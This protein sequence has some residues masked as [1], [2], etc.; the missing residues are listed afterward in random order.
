MTIGNSGFDMEA[1]RWIGSRCI[2]VGEESSE[3]GE[4]DLAVP[5]LWHAANAL[6]ERT[7]P[8]PSRRERAVSTRS[9][10]SPGPIWER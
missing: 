2:F 8:R 5:S 6:A 3:V 4:V 10:R 9:P 7:E 1:G